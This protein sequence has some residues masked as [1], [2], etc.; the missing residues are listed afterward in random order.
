M[1][2]GECLSNCRSGSLFSGANTLPVNA[3]EVSEIF[4][5]NF[6]SNIDKTSKCKNTRE[7]ANTYRGN[8]TDRI[9]PFDRQRGLKTVRKDKKGRQYG[10]I[11]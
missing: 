4:R 7:N 1:I 8:Y 6:R 2:D 11:R 10:I 9:K 3:V 5:N